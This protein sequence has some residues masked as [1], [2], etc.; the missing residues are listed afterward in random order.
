VSRPRDFSKVEELYHAALARDQSEWEPFLKGACGG[1]EGLLREVRSLLGYEEEARPLL[2]EPVAAA[3][4][5]RL[6]VVRG[7]R[8]G[9]YEVMDLV[10]SGGMGE[11]YRARDVRL[12]RD[13]AIKVLPDDVAHDPEARARLRREARA[14]AALS[15]PHIAALFDIGETDG[16]HYL[17]MELLE[18]ET[19]AARLRRGALPEKEALRIGAEVA[20]ALAAAHGR[21]VVHRDVK[22]ANVMLTRTGARL[23]DF[24]LARVQWTPRALGEARTVPT[25]LVERGIA[26]TLPYMAPEQLEGRRVDA[27]TDIWGLGCVLFEM[28]TGKRAFE[29]YNQAS[30]I[31]AIEKDETPSVAGHRP[32]SVP[33]DRLVRECLRKDPADRWQ[34]AHDLALRLREIAAGE[35]RAARLEQAARTRI[36]DPTRERR[37][38]T[39]VFGLALLAVMAVLALYR[40]APRREPPEPHET[41]LEAL[42]FTTYP[43]SADQPSFSPDGSEMAFTWDGEKQDNSDIYVKAIGS[44]QALRLTSDPAPDR[45]PAWSPDGT[46]IAFLRGRPDGGSDVR[47]VPP[48]GG[49]E[50]K[51]GELQR[52]AG[53][54]QAWSPDGRFLAVVDR[55]LPGDPPGIFLLDTT[56]GS[57][58]RLTSPSA[59]SWDGAPAFS[60]DGRTLAFERVSGV[61][62]VLLIPVAGGEPRALV[63]AGSPKG[64]LAWAPDGK[65]IIVAAEPLARRGEPP[66][67]AARWGTVGGALWRVPVDGAPARPLGGSVNAVDVA[68]SAGGHRLAYSDEAVD[69]DIWRLDLRRRGSAEE[70]PSRF[71]A[72]TKFDGSPH[73]SPD[74]GR[75]A[76]ISARSGQSEVW[77]VDGRGGQALRVS[78]LGREGDVGSP[79]WSPDGR[80]IAF[81]FQPIGEAN[82]DVYVVSASG[83]PAR[84]ITTSPAVD[85][86][87]SWSRDGRWIYFSSDRSGQWQVWKVSADG[88]AAGSARQVTRGGGLF[89]IESTDGTQVYFSRANTRQGQDAISR[90]PVEGGEEE[91][92]VESLCS[93]GGSWDVTSEGIYFVDNGPSADEPWVVRLQRFGQRRATD[94]AHLQHPPYLGG[95]AISVSPDGRWLLSTQSQGG[96]ELM[97]VEDFR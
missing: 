44:E 61:A 40:Y 25:E 82:S 48:T 8:L 84:Q 56:N 83:G 90:I 34:S 21:G 63:Q 24:G 46:Q 93:T 54:G 70:T 43:G 4:T 32:V 49:P 15:H 53:A 72:S 10:G 7:T 22:P 18:G 65:S 60:P 95:P 28:L 64:G 89:A 27:R 66:R 57:K 12:G 9:P 79:R 67:A 68:V 87:P 75:V 71:I 80:L 17:V 38:W 45:S 78:F 81:D 39:T 59:T 35:D 14:V 11:V 96:S 5:R 88:E 47:L 19:L 26:G 52:G 36:R 77:V 23:L 6:A 92:V 91:V 86:T 1:D 76:F 97:L 73:F 30:L 2:E 69:F 58:K 20:E 3:A 42:P 29:G 37:V 33:S 94:V 13:V 41:L 74:G 31:A 16:T 51:I 62:R 55:P 50:R 85:A